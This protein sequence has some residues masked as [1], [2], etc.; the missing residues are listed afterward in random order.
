METD[1]YGNRQKS[2]YIFVKTG[3]ITSMY[4]G[5]EHPKTVLL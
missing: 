3:N 5:K 4:Y 1:I 2:V